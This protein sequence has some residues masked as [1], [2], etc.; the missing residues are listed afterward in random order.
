MNEP[1]PAMRS[2]WR[3]I[4]LAGL[5]LACLGTVPVRADIT[6]TDDAGRTLSLRAPAQRIVSLSPHATE[7]L[8]AAGAGDHVVGVSA[9]SD[10]PE[11]ALALPHISGGVRMDIERVVALKPDL[12]IGWLGGNARSDLDKIQSFG[13]PV[14][15]AEPH[16]LDALPNTL[17]NI[18]RLAGTQATASRAANAYKAKLAKLRAQYRNRRPVRVFVDIATQPLITLNY[19][20]LVNDVLALCGG[21]NIFAAANLIAPDVSVESVVLEDPDAIL[22][23]DSLGTVKGMRRWWS[24]HADL[25]A[26][27]AGR[28]YSF[29]AALTLRQT[30]RVLD[31]ARQVCVTLDAVRA[32]LGR[33]RK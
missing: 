2:P 25:A 20:H 4:V 11:A 19:E 17:I 18:G 14:F 3:A 30:P 7:L 10:Y 33:E 13:I 6:V 5:A 28:V 32:S 27:R 12:A 22:F 26:V 8:F 23:S 21:R 29:P 16:K 31:G 15:I 9:F 24:E 1:T